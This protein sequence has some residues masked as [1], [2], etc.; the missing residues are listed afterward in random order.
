MDSEDF[1]DESGASDWDFQD[2]GESEY[3]EAKS[4]FSENIFPSV[5]EAIQYDLQTFGFNF[6][7]FRKRVLCCK[8]RQ[9]RS[10][11]VC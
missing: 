6:K 7:D 3:Q 2:D 1:D 9:I 10:P 5:E 4:L 8:I 11:V